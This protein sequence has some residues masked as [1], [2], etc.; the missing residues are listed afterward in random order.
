[1]NTQNASSKIDRNKVQRV[2]TPYGNGYYYGG[3]LYSDE[4]FEALENENNNN[5]FRKGGPAKPGDPGYVNKSNPAEARKQNQSPYQFTEPEEENPALPP[6]NIQVAPSGN[7]AGDPTKPALPAGYSQAQIDQLY[8]T[9]KQGGMNQAAVLAF[10]RE[11][12]TGFR[13]GQP[14]SVPAE[15]SQSQGQNPPL[16]NMM[17]SNF[18]SNVPG[19]MSEGVFYG[20]YDDTVV[21][22]G[23]M[24]KGVSINPVPGD[25]QIRYENPIYE[26]ALK[27][28]WTGQN[29]DS[30]V[31]PEKGQPQQQQSQQQNQ[32]A[33]TNQAADNKPA[34]QDGYDFSNE[35]PTF[36]AAFS[37]ARQS[38]LK[39]FKY[40]GNVHTTDTATTSGKQAQ[41]TQ[42][43]RYPDQRSMKLDETKNSNPNAAQSFTSKQ[44]MG[45]QAPTN[46]PAPQKGRYVMQNGQVVWT[47][48]PSRSDNDDRVRPYNPGT[49]AFVK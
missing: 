31:M 8:A 14:A 47:T 44:T 1:M 43:K 33:A 3:R 34:K 11:Y 4:E 40:K 16:A 20:N 29:V 5:N 18:S 13:P 37:A 25:Y 9:G 30:Q 6:S 39:T 32:Q 35:A 28:N 36:S 42:Q 22:N 41:S 24:A 26:N 49:G 2:E 23:Q 45:T 48:E 12:G 21:R 10:E 46:R 27:G 19:D 17:D 38:G 15:P 7:G